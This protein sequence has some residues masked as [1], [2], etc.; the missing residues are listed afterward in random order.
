[1][2][3]FYIGVYFMVG[4][5]LFSNGQTISGIVKD[6]SDDTPV[7][8]VNIVM[9]SL[10]KGTGTNARGEFFFKN[11]PAGEY[12]LHFS[13]VGMKDVIRKV[14]VEANKDLKLEVYM[15]MDMKSLD[16]VVVAAKG[17][18]KEIHDVKRQGT[19]VAV[20]DGK[21]LAGRGTTI[22]E[23]LNHQT[24]VKLRQ[25]GGVGNQT[26]VNIRGLEGNRVQIYMDGYALN[27]PDGSFSINDIPLQFIDRIEIYKGIVPPE[28]GGDGLGSAINVVTIEIMIC[29]IATSLTACIILRLV[30]LIILIKQIWLLL[31]SR[32]GPL[33]EMITRSLLP[34]SMI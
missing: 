14:K 28:F 26:K 3:C 9:P 34:M 11:V 12:E 4:N 30:F 24:G 18:R 5:I 10:K 25:T 20:I 8:G 31:F 33:P 32:E 23:V 1:M 29:R 16:Q 21:Q 19:P 15:Q 7:A 22:T 27:T 13:F 6:S 2:K 17:E